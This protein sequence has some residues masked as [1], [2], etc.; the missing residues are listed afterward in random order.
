MLDLKAIREDPERFRSAL[1]RRGEGPA[2]DVD[3]LLEADRRWRELTA[4]VEELRAEQNRG[5]R[6]VGEAAVQERESLI[7]QLRKVSEELGKLEPELTAAE[8]ELQALVSRLPNPPHESVPEGETDDDNQL[9]REVGTPPSFPFEPKDHVELGQG[10]GVIDLE[11]AARTSGTRFAYLLGGA[12]WVQWALVRYCLDVLTA[13]GF[14]PVVP[15]VL[16]REEAMYGTGFLP[17]DEAQLYVT[18][19]DDLYLVGTSE[20][21]LAA[22]HQGEILEPES[23][24]RR[25]VGYSTCFR[26]EA[27]A[28]GKDTRGIFRV[29]QFDKVEMFSF[30]D[31]DVSWEEHEFLLSCEEELLAGLGLPYRVMNVCTG[32]LG[33]SAAKKYDIEVWLPGQDRYRELTSCSNTTDYQARRLEVRARYPDANRHVHTLN[34]T[35]CAVGRMLIALLENFQ[36]EG[37]S[38]ALPEVLHQYLPPDQWSLRPLGT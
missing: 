18:R 3:R 16:V 30:S 12:V 37:G 10:L 29:H 21:A 6:A 11:R 1:A 25:Y 32:E 22:L 2:A 36:D 15:P 28:H 4:R 9:V 34:G 20:V 14:T 33:A 24:P 8:E 35:A 17:T 5:S 27:G 23:L 26:R 19:E 13:K 38:V 31:P 7:A